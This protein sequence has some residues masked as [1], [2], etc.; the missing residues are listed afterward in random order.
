MENENDEVETANQSMFDTFCEHGAI[1]VQHAEGVI[2]LTR[3]IW[4][5]STN[6]D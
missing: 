6:D 4:G 1:P 2:E 5:T 3:M